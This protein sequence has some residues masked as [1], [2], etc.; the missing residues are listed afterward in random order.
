MLHSGWR[1]SAFVMTPL[2]GYRCFILGRGGSTKGLYLISFQCGSW[3]QTVLSWS[4]LVFPKFPIAKVIF[5]TPKDVIKPWT[6]TN[7]VT[8]FIYKGSPFHLRKTDFSDLIRL[9]LLWKIL[10]SVLPLD[11]GEGKEVVLHV[12]SF[13]SLSFY[14]IG[15]CYIAFLKIFFLDVFFPFIKGFRNLPDYKYFS[16]ASTCYF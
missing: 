3:I 1:Y 12:F 6:F 7:Y 10:W 5:G 9:F 16:H 15:Q 11:W 4:P 14:F 13:K 8:V 2:I